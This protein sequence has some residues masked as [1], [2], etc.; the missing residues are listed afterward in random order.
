MSYVA[1]VVSGLGPPLALGSPGEGISELIAP[2]HCV[3]VY[4]CGLDHIPPRSW[5]LS[6]N[7]RCRQP[8]PA[9]TEARNKCTAIHLLNL[10]TLRFWTCAPHLENA[11][12]ENDGIRYSKRGHS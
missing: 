10:Y 5:L 8:H 3:P 6:V 9:N 2:E 4:V 11:S 7:T 12:R 1:C